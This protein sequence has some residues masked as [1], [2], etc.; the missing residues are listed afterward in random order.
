MKKLDIS[1][2]TINVGELERTQSLIA[3]SLFVMSG[4]SS[5]RRSPVSSLVKSLIGGYL[6]YRSLS[7][8]CHISQMM[9]RNTAE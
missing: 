8:H 3:G 1:D 9:E 5:I 6:V 2:K 4:L 7:G